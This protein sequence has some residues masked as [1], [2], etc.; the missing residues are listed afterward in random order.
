MQNKMLSSDTG[1]TKIKDPDLD[2]Y[3]KH[4]SS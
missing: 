3:K 1:N 2:P 4:Q